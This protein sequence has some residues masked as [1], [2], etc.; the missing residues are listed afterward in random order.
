MTGFRRLTATLALLL[1]LGAGLAA[2]GEGDSYQPAAP[3]AGEQQ[4]Q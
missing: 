2:C 1:P 4:S 3:P